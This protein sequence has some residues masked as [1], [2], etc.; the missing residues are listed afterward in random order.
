MAAITNMYGS[1]VKVTQLH[2]VRAVAQLGSFSRAARTFGV[3]QPAL[4]NG[5]NQLERVL[6]ARIFDRSSR[7]ATVTGFGQLVVPAIERALGAVEALVAEARTVSGRTGT[8][9]RMGLSPLIA[10]ELVA[11]AFEAARARA[12]GGLILREGNLA[13]LRAGLLARELDV[14]IAPSAAGS[15]GLRGRVVGRED[16]YYLPADAVRLTPSAPLEVDALGG[17][18]LL[19]VVEECGLTTFVRQTLANHGVALD[20]YPG[21]AHSYRNLVE[22]AEMGLGGALLPKSK[23][24]GHLDVARP[25]VV[26]G[27]PLRITYEAMWLSNSVFAPA[28]EGLLDAML[29]D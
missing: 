16:M 9:V 2:Y 27:E 23:L 25:V 14:M 10:P 17:V 15:E 5:I 28:I 6:G 20:R 29:A 8:H 22:W 21:E 4:S 13:D 1:D 24:V 7:G 19:L 11:K 18:P 3:S 26:D 12:G